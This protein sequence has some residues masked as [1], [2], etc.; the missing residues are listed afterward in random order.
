MSLEQ[1]ERAITGLTEQVERK[2]LRAAERYFETLE[3]TEWIEGQ[4]CIG[5]LRVLEELQRRIRSQNGQ[6]PEWAERLDPV[7]EFEVRPRRKAESVA[8][9]AGGLAASVA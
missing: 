3:Q 2:R 9:K 7:G 5:G 6:R 8:L 1:I 4:R